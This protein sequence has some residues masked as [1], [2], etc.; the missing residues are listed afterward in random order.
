MPVA[1][2]S[3]LEAQVPDSHS[4]HIALVFT[5]ISDGLSGDG[6]SDKLALEQH[7]LVNEYSDIGCEI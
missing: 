6:T 7:W 3:L 2:H 5:D 4:Q 1:P